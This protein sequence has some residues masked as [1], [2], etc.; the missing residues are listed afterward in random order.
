MGSQTKRR[1]KAEDQVNSG[2]EQAAKRQRKKGTFV[3]RNCKGMC[4]TGPVLTSEDREW[5]DGPPPPAIPAAAPQ[6][7]EQQGKQL[8]SRASSK[9]AA[10]S[11]GQAKSTKEAAAE[12]KPK[13]ALSAQ[14]ALQ[15]YLT[16][17]KLKQP[18]PVQSR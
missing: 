1:Y 13:K 17:C 3:R 15:Q 10:K 7:T 5:E 9:P 2:K 14:E 4:Y 8:P 12:P 6:P 18:M 16:A 11:G